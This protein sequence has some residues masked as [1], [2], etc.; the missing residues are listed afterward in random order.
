MTRSCLS[1]HPLA[2]LASKLT[3]PGSRSSDALP[4]GEPFTYNAPSPSTVAETRTCLG[5]ST[6]PPCRPCCPPLCLDGGKTSNKASTARTAATRAASLQPINWNTRSGE[7]SFAAG[8][9]TR[10]GRDSSTAAKAPPPRL[11]G[12]GGPRRDLEANAD[13]NTCLS[14]AHKAG[15]TPPTPTRI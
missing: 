1:L 14:I 5:A 2:G 9:T 7:K 4:T 6:P 3:T 11:R 10:N 15:Y 12:Q 13:I 8:F